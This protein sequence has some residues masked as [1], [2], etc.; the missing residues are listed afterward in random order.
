MAAIPSVQTAAVVPSIGSP[1]E[2]RTNEPV[3]QP[4]QLKP[5]ECL[6]HLTHS[7]VCHTD[8][9]AKKGDWPVKPKNPLIGGH[10]GVGI[11]V[12]IGANTTNSPVQ[13]G[14]RVGIKW[15]ANSC[16]NCEFCRK[17]AEQSTSSVL[18]L[19]SPIVDYVAD[20][21]QALYSGYTVDGTFAQYVVSSTVRPESFRMTECRAMNRFH[22][23]ITLPKSR[24]PSIVLAL[25]PSSVLYVRFSVDHSVHKVF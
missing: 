14:D 9:H 17:G 23:F 13:V 6:V 24:M 15:L 10:E 1:I 20:C 22:S 21:V 2:Q 5:G 16:L 18:L 7:G 4:A 19:G 25:R 3:V 12:A 8:L 11:I